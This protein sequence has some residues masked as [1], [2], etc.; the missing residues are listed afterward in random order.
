EGVPLSAAVGS[1]AGALPDQPQLRAMLESPITSIQ[2]FNLRL[3][4]TYQQG[5]GDP[6][7]SLSSGLVS[8]DVRD[9]FRV[10]RKLTFHSGIR[11][12]V[13][14]HAAPLHRDRNNWGPRFGF[15]YRP[16]GRTV[17]RGGYGVY[18]APVFEAIAFAERVLNGPQ[19]SQVFLPLSG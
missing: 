11:Y 6:R 17:V 9:N 13:E 3:P 16:K 10:A 4:L 5:F 15:S 18:Y 7:A 1:V 2:A 12:E 19:I 14:L 8:A